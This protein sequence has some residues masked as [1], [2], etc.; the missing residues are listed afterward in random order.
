M[1]KRTKSK[2]EVEP[3]GKKVK[4]NN[5]NGCSTIPPKIDDFKFVTTCISNTLKDDDEK[6]MKKRKS[7]NCKG[8]QNVF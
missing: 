2:V 5:V 8:D 6:E 1:T 7:L 3:V 4:N